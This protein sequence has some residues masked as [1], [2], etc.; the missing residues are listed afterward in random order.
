M[1]NS[2][3]R[4]LDAFSAPSDTNRKEPANPKKWRFLRQPLEEIVNY[5]INVLKDM[6]MSPNRVLSN[7]TVERATLQ[8][9]IMRRIAVTAQ[10]VSQD[11]HSRTAHPV[12][13]ALGMI[14]SIVLN[15]N[16]FVLR[17]RKDRLTPCRS[18]SRSLPI[19]ARRALG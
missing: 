7:E 4:A 12:K 15:A 13:V 19:I 8:Q 9:A 14:M 16:H 18:S 6:L 10:R 5:V 11:I 2:N 17:R 1:E 3:Q